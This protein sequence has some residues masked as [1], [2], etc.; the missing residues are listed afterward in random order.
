MKPRMLQTAT[1]YREALNP[2]GTIFK[3]RYGKAKT[4]KV[5]S[6][7]RVRSV[8]KVIRTA[9]GVEHDS[10]IEI[11]VPAKTHVAAGNTIDYVKIDGTTGS[12]TVVSINEA[13]NLTASRVLF[14]TLVTDGR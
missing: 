11:D 2:D 8:T 1:I 12:G 13:T 7:A 9:A 4:E 5:V 3:D 6:K 14:K 10:I